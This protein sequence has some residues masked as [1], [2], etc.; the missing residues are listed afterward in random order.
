MQ[1]EAAIVRKHGKFDIGEATLDEIRADE[2][3]VRIVAAGLCHTDVGVLEGHIPWPLPAILGHEGAGIVEAVGEAVD[4]VAVGDRVVLSFGSC[5]QCPSCKAHD[6]A[7]CDAFIPLNFYGRRMD[8]SVTHTVDGAPASA[9]FFY[10]SS[11]ATHAIAGQ[12]N[13]VKVPDDLPLKLLAPLGCGLQTGAGAVLNRLKPEAGSSLVVFGLGAVGLS[14]LMAGKVQGCT[15]LIAVDLSDSRLELAKSLGATHVLR[16]DDPDLQ[17]K[18]KDISGGGLNYSVEATGVPAVMVSAVQA[19]RTRGQAMLLGV[20]GAATIPFGSD[21]L[22]GITIHS[23]IE[24]DS[25]PDV[26]IPRLIDLYRQGQFPFDRMIATFPF[27][28]INAAVAA[29]HD[30]SAIKPVLLIGDE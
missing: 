8:G 9:P 23:S 11:F 14:A 17:A 21:I 19:L 18:L 28:D 10:Q 22:R 1:I 12:R 2:V 13:V 20:A 26:M 15:T 5:G 6:P 16:G 27:H 30:G 24:G 3:R 7:Y 29:S 25:D 4:K